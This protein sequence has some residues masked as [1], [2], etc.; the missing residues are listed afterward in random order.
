MRIWLCTVYSQTLPGAIVLWLY[1]HFGRPVA[2][3]ARKH[4]FV[5]LILRPLFNAGLLRALMCFMTAAGPP[6]E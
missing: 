3:L 6:M 1:R 4:L 5:W 2:A